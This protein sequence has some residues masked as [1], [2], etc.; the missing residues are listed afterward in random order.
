LEIGK[1][2]ALQN[3]VLAAFFAREN[4]FF[5][6]GGAA[7]AGF[8]LGHRETKDLDLFTFDDV[9]DDGAAFVTEIAR[10]FGASL[11]GIQ[12]SPDFRRYLLSR[13]E[14]AVVI[15]LV[16]DRAAQSHPE[17]N[18]VG[19]IWVVQPEE[20]LA[21]KLCTL[22][23]RSE[24]RDLVDVR[25]LENAG[26]SVEEAIPAAAAKDGGLTPG[27][28]AWVLSQMKIGEDATPPGG[29]SADQLRDYLASLIRRLTL[30]AFP[31]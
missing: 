30:L 28:L 6:T 11:E 19:N 7:L 5:L 14:D 29:V 3:D 22:L 2:T 31:K 13:G 26:Y 8:Y 9:L 15:D 23:S 17:K 25:A 4:R 16:R 1:L 12:T 24:I 21:N 20:I 27:Q 18:I 10:Q